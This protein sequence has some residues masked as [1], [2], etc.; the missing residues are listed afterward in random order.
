MRY[1][2]TTVLGEHGTAWHRAADQSAKMRC[3]NMNGFHNFMNS[4]SVS[5][6][7]SNSSSSLLFCVNT[8]QSTKT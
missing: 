1:C 8:Q 7:S 4:F 2:G 3:L 6:T 5:E